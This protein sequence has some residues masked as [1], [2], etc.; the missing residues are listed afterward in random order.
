MKV[1]KA[2]EIAP[3]SAKGVKV[4]EQAVAVFNLD[5][6]FFAISDNCTHKDHTLHDGPVADGNVVC[7]WHGARFNIRTGEGVGPR[8]WPCLKTFRVRVVGDDV[9]VE[10]QAIGA[11]ASA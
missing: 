5:G 2:A 7:P 9:E 10:S 11:A 3:G 8:P 1:A 6:E 4:G